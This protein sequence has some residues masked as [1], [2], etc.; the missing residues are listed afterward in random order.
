MHRFTV[1]GST[2]F[3]GTRLVRRLRA[4]GYEVLTP[5]RDDSLVDADLGHAIY[6]IGMTA[7]YARA[8]VYI[9]RL[10]QIA[11]DGQPLTLEQLLGVFGDGEKPE[12]DQ[13]RQAIAALQE[14]YVERGVE[15][16]QVASGYRIQVKQDMEPWVS[17]LTEE[18]P[19]RYSRALL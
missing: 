16:V 4:T 12:R 5:G 14:D 7:D 18:K 1:L 8:T 2:G 17:R 13:I 11:A 9:D 3:I 19:A 6:C 10:G 15:L